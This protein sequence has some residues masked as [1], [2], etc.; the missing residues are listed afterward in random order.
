MEYRED[1]ELKPV[2]HAAEFAL[3]FCDPVPTEFSTPPA[4]SRTGSSKRAITGVAEWWPR[5]TAPSRT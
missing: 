4:M 5:R 1:Y 2:P 3:E